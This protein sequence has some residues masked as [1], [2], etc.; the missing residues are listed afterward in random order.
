MF[1]LIKII[2]NFLNDGTIATNP[3]KIYKTMQENSK[4]IESSSQGTDHCSETS[5]WI[6]ERKR[7][8][9]LAKTTNIAIQLQYGWTKLWKKIIGRL[10]TLQSCKDNARRDGHKWNS[11]YNCRR[12]EGVRSIRICIRVPRSGG[13]SVDCTDCCLGGWRV[14]KHS[15][16]GVPLEI[17]DDEVSRMYIY[18]Q[19]RDLGPI[20]HNGGGPNEHC[21]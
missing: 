7:K 16:F 20:R 17:Q 3:Q 11:S 12:I 13:P 19:P 4:R 8:T 9:K 6:K 15:N 5:V 14:R 1:I 21:G 18:R 2:K 10:R